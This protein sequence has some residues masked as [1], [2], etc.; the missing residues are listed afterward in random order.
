MDEIKTQ[1]YFS[2]APSSNVEKP[3][4]FSALE[5]VLHD[6]SIRNIAITGAYGSGKSSILE[7]FILKDTKNSYMR[8]SLANFCE[9]NDEFVLD[10]SKAVDEHILIRLL[11]YQ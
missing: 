7:S 4:Y 11:F 9:K 2:L 3:A 8:V 10:D 5:E 1:K 6:N